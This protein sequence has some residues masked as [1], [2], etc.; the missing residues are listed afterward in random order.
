MAADDEDDP[1]STTVTTTANVGGKQVTFETEVEDSD[2]DQNDV[3][4]L[5]T[6]LEEK[7]AEAQGAGLGD[8]LQGF[9]LSPP[10]VEEEQSPD[11]ESGAGR[12]AAFS[13]L[14]R[15][16]A[17]ISQVDLR[18]EVADR[19]ERYVHED[20]DIELTEKLVHAWDDLSFVCGSRTRTVEGNYER[21]TDT[22]DIFLLDHDSFNEEVRNGTSVHATLE[23]EVIMG[24]GYLGTVLGPFLKICAWNDFLA[25]GGWAE[26]D[27]TRVEIGNVMIRSLWN[28]A[29]VAGARCLTAYNYMDDFVMRVENIGTMVDTQTNITHTGSPGSGVTSDM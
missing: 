24:G 7:S 22:T 16:E 15:S 23:S 29:H 21:I 20:E 4:T 19:I 8:W 27:A 26:A 14:F 1:G 28:M 3:D 10:P 9:G 12:S 5:F 6:E 17:A 11:S 18:L 25:W 2:L 13:D